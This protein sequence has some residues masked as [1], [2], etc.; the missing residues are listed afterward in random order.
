MFQEKAGVFTVGIFHYFL[1]GVIFDDPPVPQKNDSIRNF[2]GKTHLM[3]DDQH[4]HSFLS[5]PFHHI[6][7]FTD[8]FR[9]Q[10]RGRITL[11]SE[12]Q[13]SHIFYFFRILILT[14]IIIQAS[15]GN[16]LGIRK[17]T[18]IYIRAT[19]LLVSIFFI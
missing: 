16:V 19:I 10:G 13:V 2:P 14:S 12:K 8:Q 6:E 7:D 9:V 15:F 5:Q 11:G 17:F 1:W 18:S 3:G 4:R